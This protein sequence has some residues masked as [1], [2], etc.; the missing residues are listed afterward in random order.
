M[1]NTHYGRIGFFLVAGVALIV[2]TIIYIGGVGSKKNEF[3]A[4]TFFGDSVSGLDVGSTVTLRGVR[5]GEVRRISF[6]GVEFADAAPDDR[7]KIHVELALD[8]RLFRTGASPR[9]VLEE[10]VAKGLH[11]TVSASGVTGLSHIEL[12]FPKMALFEETRSWK[13]DNVVIPPSPSIL[14][15]AADS[16]QSILNQLDK[17]NLVEAWSNALDV[18]R[19][20]NALL[21]DVRTILAGEQGTVGEI[22]SNVREASAALRDCAEEV[23]RNPS[24]LLRN[25]EPRQLEETR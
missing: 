15:S 18:T 10:M 14:Q 2:A 6:V 19:Q 11:A 1:N 7:R 12:N 16:A 9:R 20:A 23:R 22:M 3:T 4:E 25:Y 8:R 17:M 21:G 24:A 13:S 5:V